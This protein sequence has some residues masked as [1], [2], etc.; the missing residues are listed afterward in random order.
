M[1]DCD[2]M[3][4]IPRING[5]LT[6]TFKNNVIYHINRIMEEKKI[7]HKDAGRKA[8]EKIQFLFMI[9]TLCA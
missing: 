8:L 9:K 7:C 5:C 2:Q 4:F 6:E 3:Q 1:I